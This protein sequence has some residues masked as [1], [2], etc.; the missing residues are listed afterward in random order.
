MSELIS[1]QNKNLAGEVKENKSVADRLTFKTKF[2]AFTLG[3]SLCFNLLFAYGFFQARMQVSRTSTP[4]GKVE[5][6]SARLQL[7]PEQTARLRKISELMH[8][9]LKDRRKQMLDQRNRVLTGI[10]SGT[11]SEQR[12]HNYMNYSRVQTGQ[13]RSELAGHLILFIKMLTPEQRNH[14]TK[15]IR[16]REF[17]GF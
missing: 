13:L 14:L 12:L 16:N 10:K 11:L 5:A 8:A 6:L 15:M 7:S 4:G 1:E 2:M 17:T 3:V 9:R